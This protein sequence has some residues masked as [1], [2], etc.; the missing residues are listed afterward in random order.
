MNVFFLKSTCFKR[1]KERNVWLNLILEGRQEIKERKWGDK[2]LDIT[3]SLLK[4][5][6]SP[7]TEQLKCL[8]DV[9][10]VGRWA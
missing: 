8:R 5:S 4:A 7:N 10:M 9:K 6:N 1:T 2:L 3:L